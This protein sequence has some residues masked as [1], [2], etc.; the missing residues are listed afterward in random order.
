MKRHEVLEQALEGT[1]IVSQQKHRNIPDDP[2]VPG[3][4]RSCINVAKLYVR[5]RHIRER[6]KSSSESRAGRP[7]SGGRAESE[8]TE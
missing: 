4:V 5:R 7:V 2:E 3:T 1:V 8:T 6:I